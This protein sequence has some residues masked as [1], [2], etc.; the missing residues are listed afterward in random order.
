[1]SR[2]RLSRVRLVLFV[3]VSL[4]LARANNS[5]A[6]FVLGPVVTHNG[7]LP[8]SEIVRYTPPL[9]LM[10]TDNFGKFRKPGQFIHWQALS[11]TDHVAD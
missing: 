7:H 11:I 2:A 9:S 6:V 10:T 8:S 1:M 3:C 4:T 5:Y